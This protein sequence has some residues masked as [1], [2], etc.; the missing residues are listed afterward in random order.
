MTS[1]DSE[2]EEDDAYYSDS[3]SES[4]PE[5]ITSFTPSPRLIKPLPRR[6]LSQ[7]N[8]KPA[9]VVLDEQDSSAQA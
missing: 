9:I 1:E 3:E 7:P 8:P 4:E 2:E 6:C 5:I